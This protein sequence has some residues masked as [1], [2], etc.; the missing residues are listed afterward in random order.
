MI[1][2][3]KGARLVIEFHLVVNLD[4]IVVGGHEGL[5]PTFLHTILDVVG[6]PLQRREG[7]EVEGGVLFA[8]EAGD[9]FHYVGILELV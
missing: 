8:H 6:L 3:M 5:L 9:R 2:E 4:S 7:S 1:L